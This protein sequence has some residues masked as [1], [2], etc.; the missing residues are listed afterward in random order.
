MK[1]FLSRLP[2][3]LLVFGFLMIIHYLQWGILP[4]KEKKGV[5]FNPPKIE[6][7]DVFLVA[8]EEKP[9]EIGLINSLKFQEGPLVNIHI[10]DGSIKGLEF[11]KH[12]EIDYRKVDPSALFTTFFCSAKK[13]DPKDV[14][15]LIDST[16]KNIHRS[17]FKNMHRVFENGDIWFLYADKKLH[18]TKANPGYHRAKIKACHAG[19]VHQ[20]Q[21]EHIHNFE[22]FYKAVYFLSDEHTL[23]NAKIL[24]PHE[25]IEGGSPF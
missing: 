5:V 6:K 4:T 24:D 7:Y 21:E 18:P 11:P 19:L 2:G 1:Y 25:E 20:L 13:C 8:T 22:E 9:L 16:E 12:P 3:A 17:F 15:V 10:L 14:I 23:F